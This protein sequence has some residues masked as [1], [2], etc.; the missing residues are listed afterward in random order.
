MYQPSRL[1]M[2][3]RLRGLRK[4]EL[5]ARLGVQPSSLARYERDDANEPEF[6]L[7]QRLAEVLQ[8]GPD[9][10][11][12]PEPPQV[13]PESVTFRA[14]SRMSARDRDRALETAKLAI[15]VARNVE[16]L[17]ELPTW[18]ATPPDLPDSH[19]STP[20]EIARV[21]RAE[22]ALGDRN[23]RNVVHLLES[24]GVRVFS[25]YDEPDS[26]D[27]FAHWHDKA[28]F[29]FLSQTKSAQRSRFDACHELGHIVLHRNAD[30]RG[31]AAEVQANRFAAALLMPA[32]AVRA[33][34]VR[35]PGL[36]EIDRLRG[37]FGVSIP[38]M[39]FRL[40]SLEILS[41]WRY[42]SLCRQM[43]E[44]GLRVTEPSPIPHERSA[45]WPR[46]FT[47]LRNS[48]ELEDFCTRLCVGASEIAGLTFH[49]FATAVSGG[50]SG[51]SGSGAPSE[52]APAFSP[53]PD[54]KLVR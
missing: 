51:A 4:F 34:G 46:V 28:P 23:L 3:R 37:R 40:Y 36:R 33:A 22:W 52:S 6:E 42:K 48:G 9:F 25:L 50:R 1:R 21:L 18:D 15:D 32:E 43:S 10:F 31:R 49:S 14:L 29:I 2:A 17:F 38:A 5:A 24:K 8:I 53:R 54:L 35:N 16:A 47:S 7:L 20:E 45:V 39:T 19:T 26:I 44:R 12:Q 30:H 13:E 11:Y 27:A 41:E